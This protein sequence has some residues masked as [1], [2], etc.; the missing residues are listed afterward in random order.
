MGELR[1]ELVE[2]WFAQSGGD[3]P[4]DASHRSTNRIHGIFSADDALSHFLC[5][6]GVRTS[7]GVRVD[8]LSGD[9]FEEVPKFWRESIFHGIVSFVGFG[10]EEGRDV[11]FAN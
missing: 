2:D 1:L 9:S 7:G 11:N 5:G 8:L 10:W 3:I 4:N 6:F